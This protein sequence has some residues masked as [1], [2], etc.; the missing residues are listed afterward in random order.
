MYKKNTFLYLCLPHS[1]ATLDKILHYLRR[2]VLKHPLNWM[3]PKFVKKKIQQQQFNN[4]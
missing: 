4:S 3:A 1:V 2:V